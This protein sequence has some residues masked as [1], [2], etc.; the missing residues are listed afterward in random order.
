[1]IFH[2]LG[3][4]YP[5]GSAYD[6]GKGN[7]DYGGGGGGRGSEKGGTLNS[8]GKGG[9]GDGGDDHGSVDGAINS[10]HTVSFKQISTHSEVSEN[11]KIFQL[12]QLL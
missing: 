5:D 7:E 2:Y 8:G 4:N 11:K 6:E 3:A 10:K 12:H 1:M 9:G